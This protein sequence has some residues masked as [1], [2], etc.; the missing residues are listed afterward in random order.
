MR[1]QGIT[2]VVCLLPPR[3]L[4]AYDDLLGT[5]R[6]QFGE[7]NVLWAPI[8][9]FHLAEERQLI[10]QIL[11]FFAEAAQ[12]QQKTV[13][14][15]SAG[16]GRTGHVLAAWLVSHRGMSNEEAIAAVKRQGRNAHESR[17]N[18]LSLLLDRCRAAYAQ[19]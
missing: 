5:Y 12:R 1:A 13:V 4:A 9:D 15:C 3:Q 2:R 17:D 7:H 19:S 10:E 11:P 14:H 8:A 18:T 6:Q 16:I